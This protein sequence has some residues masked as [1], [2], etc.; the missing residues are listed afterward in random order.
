MAGEYSLTGVMETASGIQLNKDST[1]QFYF[2]YGALDREG[3]GKWSVTCKQYYFKQQ[4]LP[5]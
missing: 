3:Q 4:A 2:S 5:R 1:F